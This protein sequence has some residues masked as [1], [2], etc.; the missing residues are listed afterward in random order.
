VLLVGT[1]RDDDPLPEYGKLAPTPF[2][3][4]QRLTKEHIAELSVSML[5]RAG[6]DPHLVSLLQRETEGNAFFLVEAVRTLAEEAGQLD[7]I[8]QMTLPDT[9]VSGGIRAILTRR[10]SRAPAGARPLLHLAAVA[11]RKLD[12]ALLQALEP[13]ADLESWLATAASVAVIEAQG[14]SW[15]FAHD[16]LREEVQASLSAEEHRALH[17]RVAGG[18]EAIYPD[19]PERAAALAHHWS[20]AGD[21]QKE[22]H[23]AQIAGR[24][25]AAKG[26]PEDAI[27]FFNRALELLAARPESPERA[28]RELEVLTE[29]GPQLTIAR[30]F[31]SP[32][33]ERTFL[34]AR[35][36]A[37]GTG[38]APVLF[39]TIWGQF[40]YYYNVFDFN[41]AELLLIQ[42]F[43]LAKESADDSL[44]LAANHAGWTMECA[45]GD[46]ARAEE[47]IEQ[48]LAIYDPELHGDHSQHYGHDSGICALVNGSYVYS[49]MGYP[50]KALGRCSEAQSLAS[51]LERPVEQVFAEFGSGIVAC[52]RGEY[53]DAMEHSSVL[54]RL[55]EELGSDYFVAVGM[56]L[57][58]VALT[59]QD[60]ANEG[61]ATTREALGRL[62][63][64]R[65]F[66]WV[67][68]GLSGFL[69]ACLAAGAVDEGLQAIQDELT[70]SKQTGQ[71]LLE[72]EVRRLHGE[73]LLAKDSGTAKEAEREIQQAIDIARQQSARS[74][75]LR[76][77]MSLARLWKRQGRTEQ[78]R[79]ILAEI[80]DWFSEGFETA[81]LLAARKLLDELQ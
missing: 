68:M 3:S 26:A 40:M 6:S 15:R 60:Q 11:G 7:R 37:L 19:D 64:V 33:V 47:Y 2:L 34:R 43:R 9:I 29:L 57:R 35:E 42:L 21:P 59:G 61:L 22:L 31:G 65:A 45:R 74:L 39:R 41:R 75:E 76:A 24:Q 66:A 79:I 67:P 12:L 18:L 70:R 72:S 73:L 27:R 56:F 69:E 32:L 49:L 46:L 20:V 25:A 80:Y 38:S 30:G 14:Q 77:V 36:L 28:V 50:D 55:S 78:A 63:L 53:Q 1:Y 4:L 62:M 52:L 48:G 13:G 8:H 71:R 5:G 44:I 17:R 54:L 51:N 16:K 23:Y 81:D 58:G 10:L